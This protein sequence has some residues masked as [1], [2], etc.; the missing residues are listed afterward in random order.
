MPH[1]YNHDDNATFFDAGVGLPS[2]SSP[3][4]RFKLT[5]TLSGVGLFEVR[6]LAFCG[7]AG[8]TSGVVPLLALASPRSFAAKVLEETISA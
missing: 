7:E 3:A 4:L 1:L 2:T 8:S 5:A 6:T